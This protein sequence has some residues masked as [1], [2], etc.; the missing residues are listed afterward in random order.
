MTIPRLSYANVMATLAVIIAVGGGTYALASDP[1]EID[2]CVKVAG[3]GIGNIRIVSDPTTC[4]ANEQP[5]NWSQAGPAG[6][7]GPAG[8]PDTPQQVLNKIV[9]VDGDG[10]GLDSSFLD[11]IN[12]TGF[13]RNTGKAVDADKLDGINSS[14]FAEQRTSSTGTI[15]L[16]AIAANKCTDV[17]FGI[18]KIQ[19]HD[20]VILSLNDDTLPKNL[21]MSPQMA[22]SAGLLN[23]R[24]CNP[25][26]TASLADSDIK[27][28]WNILK[29]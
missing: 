26:N 10:S 2:A 28:R 21:I 29:P 13:L 5:L 20:S 23:V 1:G 8:S 19:A 24:I 14:D 11:G 27:V 4:T 7:A 25:T 3:G 15:G 17:Q 12:S 16:S 22:P 18:A 9:Q 6:P